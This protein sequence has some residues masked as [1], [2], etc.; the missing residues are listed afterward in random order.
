[1]SMTT[2]KSKS[3]GLASTVAYRKSTSKGADRSSSVSKELISQWSK[4]MIS[5]I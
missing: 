4:S 5:I 3:G 2:W 1:M